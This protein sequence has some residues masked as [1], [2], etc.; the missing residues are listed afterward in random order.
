MGL[1]AAIQTASALLRTSWSRSLDR[2]TTVITICNLQWENPKPAARWTVA[3][4]ANLGPR[5]HAIVSRY[6]WAQ[7]TY[8]YP[9]LLMWVGRPAGLKRAINWL[10]VR[11]PLIHGLIRFSTVTLVRAS[12]VG[13]TR[14]HLTCRYSICLYQRERRY[15]TMLG[16]L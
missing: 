15:I 14:F 1:H 2:L 9:R 10:P 7:I 11:A 8:A 6:V 4:S 12:N 16:L 5:H 3:Y 13:K